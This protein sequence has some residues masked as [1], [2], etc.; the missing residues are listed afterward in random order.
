MTEWIFINSCGQV[1]KHQS[2]FCDPVSGKV[3]K[4]NGGKNV[5]RGKV[6]FPYLKAIYAI[7]I[8]SQQGAG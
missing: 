5:L 7:T 6:R 4:I 3:W 2:K 1:M 8:F